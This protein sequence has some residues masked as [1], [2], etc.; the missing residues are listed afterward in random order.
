[1][2]PSK[3]LV[4]ASLTDKIKNLFINNPK[5]KFNYKQIAKKIPE[6]E[7]KN[8]KHVHGLM[9][10]LAKEGFI[11]E[12]Y[13]GK[14]VLNP[15]E[16]EKLQ[17]IGP[18]ITGTVD[19]K[20][21][22]KAYVIT[23]ELLEDVRISS[24]N[25]H[26]ALNG[27]QV[28]VRLFPKRKDS[29]IEGEI[30]EI[31]KR[32]KT[33][34]VGIIEKQKN[35]AFLIPDN[36]STP[37]DIFI[38]LDQLNGAK[39]GQKAVAELTE[40][41]EQTKNP[42]GKIV[43]VLGTPGDNEVEI[44]AILAEYNLPYT[45]A[46]EVEKE[47]EKLSDKI[48]ESEISKRNDYRKILTFTI[49][50]F[51]AKDFD[52]AISYEK[53][54]ENTYR[55]GVHIADVSHYIEEKTILDEEAYNRATSIYLVDRV[56]PMLP[57]RL[58]NFIC[59]LRPKEDK[60]TFAVIF[61]ITDKGKI[62][63]TWYGKTIINSDRRFTYEEVQEIIEN[64][65]G[66]YKD[67]I[68]ILDSIAK[69]I[70]KKRMKNGAIGF[71][72]KEIKFRLDEKGKPLSVYH[73]EQK[74]AHKLIEEFM[75][76]ANK[77]VAEKIGKTKTGQAPKTFIYR[78]HDIPNPEKLSKLSEFVSKMGY[79]MKTD[80][81]KNI[82]KSFNTLLKECEGKGEENLIETLAIRS[83]AKAEYSTQ[84]IGHYGL[85]FDHYTHFT[86][87]IRR[88]PDMMVHRLLYAYLNKANSFPAGPYEEKCT[89]S[90]E[91]EKLAQNAERD[92]IKLKQVEFL[93]DKIGLTF[94]GVISGVSKW[95][96]FVELIEN[97][98]EGMIRLKDLSDDY[99]YLDEDNYQVLGHNTKRKFKLGDE[100][101][102]TIKS[103]DSQRKE[104]DFALAI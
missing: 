80:T 45:F 58:S 89:H 37:I 29:K 34:F 8:K 55:V 93:S 19:M 62:L 48:T 99:Y 44:H 1:M 79:S 11:I 16:R 47:A 51:D 95:G 67:E 57:E 43:Q 68:L 61:D 31:I 78:I 46:E 33:R 71:D 69:E 88:Y 90:T 101:M 35:F 2:K 87:P 64:K 92:S 17:T 100:L 84:N 75:L 6:L 91:M 54:D 50:P 85:A 72:K 26:K 28:K 98:C 14:Y 97:K 22:G 38:P 30:I 63:S 18:I 104:I 41:P 21:T 102:V 73:K 53:I 60:L 65:E 7:E 5:G 86:S 83:M 103:V 15:I 66:E 70:R 81:R 27:D 32:H 40:W 49:D 3:E 4:K 39:H 9:Y 59:S 82:S 96:L 24:N 23:S 13:K 20:Q 94:Q 12:V 77:A 25:T 36:K 56:V 42:F 10:Q 74:D 76:L 52:D